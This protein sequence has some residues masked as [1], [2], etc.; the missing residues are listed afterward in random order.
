MNLYD[1]SD[2]TQKP[3]LTWSAA[4]SDNIKKVQFFSEHTLISASSD[5]TVKLWDLR[6]HQ[7]PV[8]SL[9]LE[10]PVEDFCVAGSKLFAAHGSSIAMIDMGVEEEGLEMI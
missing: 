4:H 2:S 3:V 10:K 8:G 6:Q 1:I 9:S 5:K 7:R